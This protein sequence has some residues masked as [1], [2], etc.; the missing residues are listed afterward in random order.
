MQ[1]SF[2]EAVKAGDGFLKPSIAALD[3]ALKRQE[4]LAGSLF[5]KIEDFT[6]GKDLA[7]TIDN[8]AE[9]LAAYVRPHEAEA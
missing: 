5:G 4:Q 6:F 3:E 7:F 9:A 2:D 8:L 1:V